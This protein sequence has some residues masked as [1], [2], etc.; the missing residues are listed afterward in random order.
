VVFGEVVGGY[1]LVKKIETFGSQNGKT[2]KKI[3]ISASGEL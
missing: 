2:S 1:D 3:T